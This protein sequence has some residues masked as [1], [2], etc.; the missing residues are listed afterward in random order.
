MRFS[1]N[2][3]S[4]D[5]IEWGLIVTGRLDY[6]FSNFV[7]QMKTTEYANSIKGGE[8]DSQIAIDEL[9]ELCAKYS[10]AVREDLIKIF[11]RW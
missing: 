5:R 7:L 10:L 8:L 6:K 4:K 3:P 9:Y 2:I 11:K 1:S